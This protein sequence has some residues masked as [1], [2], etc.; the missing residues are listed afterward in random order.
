MHSHYPCINLLKLF[1]NINNTLTLVNSEITVH[2]KKKTLV[3]LLLIEQICCKT[4]HTVIYQSFPLPLA[5]LYWNTPLQTDLNIF[6]T[7]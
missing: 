5:C 1:S 4:C 7:Q 2:M 6:H 3:I